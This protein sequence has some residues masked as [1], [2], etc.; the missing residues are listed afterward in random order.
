MVILWNTPGTS[1]SVNDF[2][3]KTSNAT[4]IPASAGLFCDIGRGTICTSNS[5]QRGGSHIS[6]ARGQIWMWLF[7]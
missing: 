1:A 5:V 4:Y 6:F 2:L 7:E 3:S